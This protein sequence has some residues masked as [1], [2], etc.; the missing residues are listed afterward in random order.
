VSERE[1][2]SVLEMI[3]EFLREAAVLVLVFVPLEL[4]KPGHQMP[5]RWYFSIVGFSL[6]LLVSGIFLERIRP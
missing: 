4:N 6:C 3:G 5:I 1:K 2:V